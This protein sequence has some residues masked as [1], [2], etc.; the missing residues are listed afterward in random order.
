VI[1]NVALMVGLMAL[2]AVVLVV[3]LRVFIY[4]LGVIE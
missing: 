4:L 3:V 2:G 1:E